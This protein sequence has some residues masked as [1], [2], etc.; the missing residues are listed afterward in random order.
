VVSRDVSGIL[1][2]RDVLRLERSGKLRVPL[3]VDL[4]GTSAEK[5]EPTGVGA[6]TTTLTSR[7]GG[8]GW[9]R[10]NPE[11]LCNLGGI[12]TSG[13]ERLEEGSYLGDSV[14]PK[15][16]LSLSFTLGQSPLFSFDR[17]QQA[18]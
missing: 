14:I 2:R 8:R 9:T 15:G 12:M 3:E 4:D 13:R 7:I 18:G 1:G 17:S 10:V 6:G 5:L 11:S 16:G